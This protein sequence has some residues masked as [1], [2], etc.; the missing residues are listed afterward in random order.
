MDC[1]KCGEKK[2]L[3][4]SKYSG[5]NGFNS[6]VCPK[7]GAI[8]DESE[9]SSNLNN[10]INFDSKDFSLLYDKL[11]QNGEVF[12]PYSLDK[13]DFVKKIMENKSDAL[14]ILGNNKL[15]NSYF[16][17]NSKYSI[18]SSALYFQRPQDYAKFKEIYVVDCKTEECLT[19]ATL[20]KKVFIIYDN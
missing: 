15:I 9:I 1:K 19:L 2:T 8:F 4:K 17:T 18:T 3:A 7:C 12:F 14:L 10:E 11:K 6:F 20:C 13:R 5:F 16:N